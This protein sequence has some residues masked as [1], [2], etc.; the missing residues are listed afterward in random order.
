MAKRTLTYS[1][2]IDGARET[3]KALRELPKDADAEIRDRAGDIAA[4]LVPAI[5]AAARSDRSPQSRL[6]A[7]TVKVR[8]DRLPVV[9]AGARRRGR[10]CSAASS[11]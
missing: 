9:V 7:S 6:M 11:A 3:L 10:C 4:D 8:R 2:H 5:Q 1:L